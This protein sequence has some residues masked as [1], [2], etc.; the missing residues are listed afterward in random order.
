MLC[1][2]VICIDIKYILLTCL[3]RIIYL[4]KIYL[5]TKFNINW[6]YSK[7]P[8]MNYFEMVDDTTA[9]TLRRMEGEEFLMEFRRIIESK[10]NDEEKVNF[11]NSLLNVEMNFNEH[12]FKRITP[13]LSQ[14]PS[15]QRNVIFQQ[16]YFDETCFGYSDEV[17]F[18]NTILMEVKEI[19]EVFHTRLVNLIGN[20]LPNLVSIFRL[21]C[22]EIYVVEF[23]HFIQRNPEITSQVVDEYT[24]NFINFGGIHSIAYLRDNND[25]ADVWFNRLEQ[26]NFGERRR[27]RGII[28]IE[29]TENVM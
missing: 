19:N 3:S 2:E 17:K 24:D 27:R 5:F 7:L 4:Y 28:P 13:M 29:T 10:L 26:Y 12:F 1:K 15:N 16:L 20:D 25:E 11:N 6:K 8:K 23:K 18:G 21:L 14:I 22:H 9:N